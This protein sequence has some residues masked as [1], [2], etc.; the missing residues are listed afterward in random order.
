MVKSKT[1]TPA[2]LAGGPL[3]L[4]ADLAGNK[5]VLQNISQWLVTGKALQT[6]A[7]R[8]CISILRPPPVIIASSF[9]GYV[10]VHDCLGP[11][12]RA[13]GLVPE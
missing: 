8:A 12:R 9:R 11:D 2:D 1:R 13:E 4:P 3:A 10:V 5:L 6:A 7:A